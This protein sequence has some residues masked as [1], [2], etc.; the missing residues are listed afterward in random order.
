CRVRNPALFLSLLA[1]LP[2]A[3]CSCTTARK[4]PIFEAA[5]NGDVESVKAALD[6]DATLLNAGE[7]KG[8][9]NVTGMTP[10]HSAADGNTVEAGTL[11]A[12]GGADLHTKNGDGDMPLHTAARKAHVEFVGFLLERGA[13]VNG[14]G[15]ADETP[16][17]AA[18]GA[19]DVGREKVRA[20]V[21]RLVE[22][23]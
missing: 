15:K 5:R 12:D 13:N 22:K 9:F 11:L 17:H 6:A 16:L 3:G 1:L 2:T 19:A 20:V 14:K 4:S 21:S 10:L 23:G 7:K 18:V 8:L